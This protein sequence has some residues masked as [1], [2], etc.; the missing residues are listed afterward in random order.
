MHKAIQQLLEHFDLANLKE[1]IEVIVPLTQVILILLLAL[2]AIQL[3]ARLL[4]LLKTHLSNRSESIE[5]QKRIETLAPER[6]LGDVEFAHPA[7]IG[8]VATPINC[9]GPK[10]RPARGT[11]RTP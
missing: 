1:W 2:G 3:A 4:T 11:R 9:E 10:E 5:D 6:D 8:T 7:N